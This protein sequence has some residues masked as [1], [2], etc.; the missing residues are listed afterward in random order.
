MLL[1]TSDDFFFK[2]NFFKKKFKNTIRVSNGFD[3][4]QDL[5]FVGPDLGPN[6]SQRLSAEDRWPL[7][8][9]KL[10]LIRYS[11]TCVKQ[12]L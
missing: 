12:P 9:K 5:H 1:L 6:C 10:K 11:K 2:I 7:A 4:D 3:P 8:R